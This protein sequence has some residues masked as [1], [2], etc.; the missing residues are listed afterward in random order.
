MLRQDMTPRQKM[1]SD[2]IITAV[3]GG[4]DYWA[5]FTKYKWQDAD[6]CEVAAT[7][8]IHPEDEAEVYALDIRKIGSAL[9][10]MANGGGFGRRE[11]PEW[12]VKKW[13]KAY[14]ECANGSWDF[15]AND[16]DAIVQVAIFGEVVYG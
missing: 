15:D 11:A 12:W 6:G 14:R 4:S 9:S 2:I 10:R 7:V 13:R 5:F 8:T 3:E 1:Y 16:A